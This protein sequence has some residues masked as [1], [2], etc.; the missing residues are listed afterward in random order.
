MQVKKRA[1]IALLEKKKSENNT[2]FK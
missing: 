2:L 1:N